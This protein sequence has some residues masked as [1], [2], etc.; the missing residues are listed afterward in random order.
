VTDPGGLYGK[1]GT[2]GKTLN[3]H[4]YLLKK[5]EDIGKDVVAVK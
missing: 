2:E 1:R 5:K 4:F 3:G